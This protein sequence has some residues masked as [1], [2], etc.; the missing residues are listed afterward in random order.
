MS[1]DQLSI[2]DV[3]RAPPVSPDFELED[4]VVKGQVDVSLQLPHKRMAWDQAR[5]E[6]HQHTSGL[7]M[8]GTG[9][10]RGGDGW[11]YRVGSKWGNFAETKDDA[12]Y[13]A[14]DEIRKRLH[15]SVEKYPADAGIMAWLETLQ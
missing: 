9:C 13:Y 11:G 8:W 1:T 2:F 4:S 6:L 3:M 10:N 7:W 15:R 14:I 5:I 12:L